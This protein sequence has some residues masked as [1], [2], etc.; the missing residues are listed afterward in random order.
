M[1]AELSK[2]G[3]ALLD[4]DEKRRLQTAMWPS[5]KLSADVMARPVEHILQVAGLAPRPAKFL[6]VEETG[7]GK[8][9]PFSG[10]KL[11]LVLTVYRARSFDEAFDTVRRIYAYQ[12][13]GHSVGI[14][15]H[16]EAQ[17]MRLGL[18][19]PAARV[20]VNQA[21]AIATG[22]AFDNGLPFS[23]SMGCGTWGRNSISE[24]LSYRHYLNIT[25]IVRPIAPR[26]P[27]VEGLFGDYFRKHGR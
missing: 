22:G 5:G 14:H 15:T 1:L 26:V 13:A 17:V 16:D 6:M 11:S 23:L 27:T 7:V 3:G 12:G 19:M 8:D 9:S 25:R 2:A 20:I 10:E 18:E 24:N 4:G 21:H